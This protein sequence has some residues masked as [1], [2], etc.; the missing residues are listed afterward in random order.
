MALIDF[1][2]N[3]RRPSEWNQWAEVVGREP[4]KSRFV[5]DMPHGWVASDYGRSLLDMFAFERPADETLVLMA[6]VPKAWTEEEGF[7]VKNLRTP[8]GP[9]SYSLRVAGDQVVLNVEEIK[10]PEGGLAVAWPE[11]D[12]PA[13]QS[14]QRGQARWLGTEMRI[15]QLPFTIVFP[16]GG[17]SQ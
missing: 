14:I 11:G 16:R 12:Q 2:M 4:R 17:G 9:L 3:D 5:G 10:M 6:G 8:F 7:A 13:H 15:T 1:L